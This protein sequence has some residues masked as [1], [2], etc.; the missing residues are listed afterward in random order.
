MSTVPPD[1]EIDG[2]YISP[3][4]A[5]ETSDHGARIAVLADP[6]VVIHGRPFSSCFEIMHLLEYAFEAKRALVFIGAGLTDSALGNLVANADQGGHRFAAVRVPDHDGSRR[7][8]L[9]EIATV[10][11]GLVID[12]DLGIEIGQITTPRTRDL[13]LGSAK[14][15]QIAENKTI[16]SAGGGRPVSESTTQA[17][18]RVTFPPAAV[19][20]KPAPEPCIRRAVCE[21]YKHA[22]Q[23]GM[24]PPNLKEIPVPVQEVLRFDGQSA[25]ANKIQQIAGENCF[26]GARLKPGKRVNGSLSPFSLEGRKKAGVES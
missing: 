12:E 26:S 1:F 11:G 8:K 18:E 22:K 21:V 10:T 3:L 6:I 9:K 7:T 20:L 15:V 24:K 19:T 25:S 17:A 14:R 2:G 23:N 4:F 13:V 16:I 5:T